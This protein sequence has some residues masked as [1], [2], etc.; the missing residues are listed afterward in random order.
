MRRIIHH[1]RGICRTQLNLLILNRKAHMETGGLGYS[2][3][4]TN[5]AQRSTWTVGSTPH[6]VPTS[7]NAASQCRD[8]PIRL[9]V[10]AR[11]ESKRSAAERHPSRDCELIF[12]MSCIE[13]VEITGFQTDKPQ[14]Q[15]THNTI[16]C[17]RLR[18]GCSST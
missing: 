9:R 1:L 6:R 2:R 5:Y 7:C 11:T 17:S 3:I 10:P 8:E 12:T 15:P 13:L 14:I 4:C 18:K 16:L